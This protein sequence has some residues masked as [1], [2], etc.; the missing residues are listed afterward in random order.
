MRRAWSLT[1]YPLT[2]LPTYPVSYQFVSTDSHVLEL[3]DRLQAALSDR[4]ALEREIGRG[5][6]ATV[7]LASDLKH[8]RSV[9]IK[10]FHPGLAENLGPERFR[11]EVEIAAQ[12][13]HPHILRGIPGI[14]LLRD[15]ICQR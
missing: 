13:S 7:Y 8:R 2:H 11:R 4:Y 6:M 10:V 14:P 9:A 1:S 12:L 5:G 3:Q 15:A